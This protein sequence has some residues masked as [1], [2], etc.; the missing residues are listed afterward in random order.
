MTAEDSN[1]LFS[2]PDVSTATLRLRRPSSTVEFDN[3]VGITRR[4]MSTGK[5]QQIQI[6][7]LLQPCMGTDVP[8]SVDTPLD[9]DTLADLVVGLRDISKSLSMYLI[10]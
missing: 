8:A 2:V 3:S 6:H 1:K 4:R 5:E 10:H 9:G 7:R